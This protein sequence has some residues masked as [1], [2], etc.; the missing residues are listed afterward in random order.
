M[1]EQELIDFERRLE[2]LLRERGYGS[3]I[4]S[5]GAPDQDRGTMEPRARLAFLIEN[6]GLATIGRFEL[7]STILTSLQVDSLPLESLSF[8]PD[9]EEGGSMDRDAREVF[10][11]GRMEEQAPDL[12]KLRAALARADEEVR[13]FRR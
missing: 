10:S 3:V 4:D 5:S 11:R 12:E 6:L 2:D 1:D 9:P 8:E 13:R 7:G